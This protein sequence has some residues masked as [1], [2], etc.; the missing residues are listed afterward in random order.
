MREE[1]VKDGTWD[2]ERLYQ[3]EAEA[4]AAKRGLWFDPH[5]VP[6]WEWRGTRQRERGA[7][8]QTTLDTSPRTAKRVG[9]ALPTRV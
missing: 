3:L 4:R 8:S 7:V 5:A 9:H 2:V 6:P 1:E